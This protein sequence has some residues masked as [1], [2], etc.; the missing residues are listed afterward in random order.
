MEVRIVEFPETKIAVAEHRGPPE[1]EYE[2]S[3]ELRRLRGAQIPPQPVSR[4][5]Q[6]SAR[7]FQTLHCPFK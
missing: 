1:F 4:W 6:T 3:K 5:R 7:S 2:T